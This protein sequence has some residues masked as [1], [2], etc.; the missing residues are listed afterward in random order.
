MTDAVM[1][2]VLIQ[3]IFDVLTVWYTTIWYYSVVYWLEL[4][5]TS[6]PHRQHINYALD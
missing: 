6:T 3:R 1:W 4:V 5:T 2:C